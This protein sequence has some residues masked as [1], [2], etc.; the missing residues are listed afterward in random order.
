MKL[1]TATN[2]TNT[3]LKRKVKIA[4]SE[5]AS[6]SWRVPLRT[7]CEKPLT[8]EYSIKDSVVVV[9]L[10]MQ[11][12]IVNRFSLSQSLLTNRESLENVLFHM[13]KDS[14]IC[15]DKYKLIQELSSILKVGGRDIVKM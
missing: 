5:Y 13:L 12:E 9:S 6:T 4:L 14:P 3:T 15:T 7:S 8:M 11:N 1:M 2:N 10:S